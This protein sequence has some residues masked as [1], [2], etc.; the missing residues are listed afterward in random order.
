MKTLILATAAAAAAAATLVAGAASAQPY[1]Y[2]SYDRPA[3]SNSYYGGHSNYRY[4]DRDRDGVP[5]RYDRYDN[6]RDRWAWEH[7]HRRHDWRWDRYERR[8]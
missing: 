4:A 2:R 8:W 7:R 3:Y 1:G 5:D 6:R